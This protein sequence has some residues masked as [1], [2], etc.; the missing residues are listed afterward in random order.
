MSDPLPTDDQRR[1]L[2]EM[3]A[4]AFVDLRNLLAGD[5]AP[6]DT[7]RAYHLAYTF[8]NLPREMYG[9]GT[10]SADQMRGRLARYCDMFPGGPDYLA[11]FNAIFPAER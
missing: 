4:D 10:W 7:A 1:R 2:N 11:K 6:E 8:H 5:P 9:W 3:V